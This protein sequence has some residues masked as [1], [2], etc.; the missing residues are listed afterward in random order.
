MEISCVLNIVFCQPAQRKSS[1][2]AG[3]Q[4]QIRV[5]NCRA[6]LPSCLALPDSSRLQRVLGRILLEVA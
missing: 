4:N 1:A 2:A 6:I 5:E 3:T